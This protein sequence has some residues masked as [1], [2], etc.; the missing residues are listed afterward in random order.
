VSVQ[1]HILIHLICLLLYNVA[2]SDGKISSF[3]FYCCQCVNAKAHQRA[4]AI[5]RCFVTRDPQLLTRAYIA[6]VRLILEHD[7]VT[8]SPHLKQDIEKIER[9]Q[10][11]YTKRLC[12]LEGLRYG[13]RLRRLQ[14]CTLELRRLHFDLYMCYRIIFGCVIVRVSE[15]FEFSHPAQTRGHPYKLYR[16]HSCNNVTSFYILIHLVCLL[17]YS[18]RFYCCQC[19]SLEHLYINSVFYINSLVCVLFITTQ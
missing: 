14:L 16:R 5:L 11:R 8:W 12:G 3:H 9:V 1:T 15:F 4:N 2:V 18:F 7:C 10:R 13:E 19:L 17:L 6:Y